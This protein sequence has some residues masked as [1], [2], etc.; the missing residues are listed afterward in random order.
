MSDNDSYM[1]I[2]KVVFIGGRSGVGKSSAGIAVSALLAEKG[3]RH[4]LIEGD[5]LDLAYPAPHLEYPEFKLAERNLGSMWANYAE[6]GY[7]R[8]IYTNTVSVIGSREL[9]AALGTPVEDASVLLEASDRTVLEWLT[10]RSGGSPSSDDVARSAEAAL[11]L[12]READDSV[13]RIKTDGLSP[14]QV[15]GAISDHLGWIGDD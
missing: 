2:T 11:R 15:A 5:N 4:V 8:L 10:H 13:V 9:I 12:E 3:V 6:L 14:A 1:S 7:S